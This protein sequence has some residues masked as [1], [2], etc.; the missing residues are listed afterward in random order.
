MTTKVDGCYNT[1]LGPC[2]SHDGVIYG[3]NWENIAAGATRLM[4]SREPDDPLAE[5]TLRGSQRAYIESNSAFISRLRGEY[6]SHYADYTTALLEAEA[7]HADTHAKRDLR[8]ASWQDV[9]DHN[10]IY[11]DVWVIPSKYALYKVKIF[12][13]AKPGKPI[14][15]I[16]DLGCPASLQGFRLTKF[17]KQAMFSQKIELEGG[18]IEFCK[19]PS[20]SALSTIFENLIDPPGRY[21]FVYFSDDSCLSIRT[22]TGILRCNIDISSCDASHTAALFKAYIDIHPEELREDATRLVKQ[23]EQAI[24]VCDPYD[25]KRKVTLKPKE[26]RLYSGATI[27]TA[28]NNLACILLGHAFAT[29]KIENAEDVVAAARKVG[30]IVTCE[31]C[32]D[33]HDLQFLKHSPVYDMYGII[34]PLLNLGVLLRMSGTSKGDVP[35]DKTETMENRAVRHQSSLLQGAYPRAKFTLINN[36]KESCSRYEKASARV[37]KQI[38]RQI[39]DMFAYK[40]HHEVHDDI[41]HVKSSEVFARYRLNALEI[42]EMECDFGRCG[43]GDHYAS[44]ATDLIYKR[45]YGLSARYLTG[46]PNEW[47]RAQFEG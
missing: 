9:I 8:I 35:G 33:W 7:H 3:R 1:R 23:C 10:L 47:E 12:E 38:D 26:P 19:E 22:S 46:P 17:T 2:A 24:T 15:C 18:V 39:N 41:F 37:Q 5:A 42:A 30:Y 29:N 4:K 28:I 40:L 14:R 44:S 27:T 36:M 45:D 16:G 6:E 32:R 11:D 13:V 43:Y 21:S 31:E 34:R 25:K 20:A